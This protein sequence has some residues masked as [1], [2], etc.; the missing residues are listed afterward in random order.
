[1]QDKFNINGHKTNDSEWSDNEWTRNKGRWRLST[2]TID[3]LKLMKW[4]INNGNEL[5]EILKTNKNKN[6]N[7][8]I[9]I[10]NDEI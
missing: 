9:G 2:H 3:G 6:M 5:N 7:N 4:N 8:E 10:I 1:M